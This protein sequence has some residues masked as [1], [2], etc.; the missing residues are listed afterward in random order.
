MSAAK[1][2]GGQPDDRPAQE[3]P[4]DA[5]ASDGSYTSYPDAALVARPPNEQYVCPVDDGTLYVSWRPGIWS[6]RLEPFYHCHS[7]AADGLDSARYNDALRACG[8][9][10][11]RLK[12]GDFS[13]FGEP[14]GAS[15]AEPESLPS[16]ATIDGWASR[17]STEPDAR[18]WL[19]QR[20]GLNRDTLASYRLGY[21]GEAITFPIYEGGELVGL[22]RRY[23][24]QPWYYK[25][26]K[27]VW[28]R[29]LAGMEALL[30]PL[31]ILAADPAA[32][33]ICEGEL[34]CLLLN[35]HGIPALT[36]TAGPHWKE[37]WNVYLVGRQIA[38]M[39]DAGSR[40]LATRRALELR[41]AGA[42]AAWPVD[43]TRAGFAHGEDVS[44]WFIKY[45]RSAGA[46][47]RLIN[48]SR[49]WHR[50]LKGQT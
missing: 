50:R 13:E 46:L 32:L 33:V 2:R 1:D 36:S 41:M 8:I 22:K 16:E 31:R 28:K 29:T 37:E 25:R 45:G 47:R 4:P 38:V 3:V 23:T 9:H 21:D 10:P 49:R 40:E 43:L 17:L 20:R 11:W 34:D 35:Q 39:Y 27:P 6:Q 7:C 5:S 26:G 12:N 19:I 44:D 15:R 14:I 24:P 42:R 48:D 18:R 30:Y